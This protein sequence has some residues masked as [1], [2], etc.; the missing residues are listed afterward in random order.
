MMLIAR[1]KPVACITYAF[2]RR[3]SLSL[4]LLNLS[5]LVTPRHMRVRG[6][7]VSIY[8]NE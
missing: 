4:L 5:S 2:K 6:E 1:N 3:T 8:N 7:V